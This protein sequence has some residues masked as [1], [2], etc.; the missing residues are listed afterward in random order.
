[1][2]ETFWTD[3][4]AVLEYIANESRKFKI[5]VANRV[6]M[7]KEGSDPSQWFYV[8]S[9]ENPANYSSRGV[10][11][12]NV[13]AVKMWFE[14]PSF[15]WRS[16]STWNIDKSKR[17]LSLEDPEVKKE[18]H[19]YVTSLKDDILSRLEKRILNW[20]KM[21]HIFGMVLQYKYKPLSKRRSTDHST[22]N[23]HYFHATEEEIIRMVQKRRFQRKINT[24]N[25]G[26]SNVKLKEGST[27]YNVDPFMGADGLIRVG[28]R[29]KHSYRNNSCK[30]PVLLEKE[31]K[32]TDLVLEWCHARCAH[33][34]R[35][36]TLNELR[37][38]G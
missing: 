16:T 28:G 23:K 8:N 20:N 30:H 19:V 36:A 11:A 18:A 38:S 32:V 3:S 34:G 31:E 14:G 24:M 27:I 35:G 37:R 10:E 7:I 2:K 25:M 22:D 15:L 9:K 5:F 6:E 17:R 33:G 26:E 13:N 12:N 1:M 4:E 21:K 29:L